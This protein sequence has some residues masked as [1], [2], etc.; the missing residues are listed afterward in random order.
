MALRRDLDNTQAKYREIRQKQMEAQL[1]ESLEAGRKGERFS[2][3]EPPLVPEEPASPNRPMIVVL[4]L[5][6]ALVISAGTAVGLELTDTRIRGAAH[7]ASL[8]TAPPLAIIPRF[9]PDNTAGRKTRR[10]ILAALG[11]AAAFVLALVAIHLF[12]RPLDVLWAI[13]LRKVGG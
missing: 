2:L 8:L 1:S 9:D 7:L 12:Y 11:L 6:M 10:R 5:V 13:V 4:G 3:I